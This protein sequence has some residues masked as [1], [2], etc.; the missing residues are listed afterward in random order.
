MFQSI[1]TPKAFRTVLTAA[2]V[3]LFATSCSKKDMQATETPAEVTTATSAQEIEELRQFVISTTGEDAVT[4]TAASKEFIIAGDAAMSLEDA[5]A[6]LKKFNET[7]LAGTAAGVQHRR[8]YYV[9]APAKA[10][11]VKIYADRTVPAV[12][13]TAL[14]KAIANWNAAGSKLKITRITTPTGAN[15]TVKGVN[16]GGNGVLAVANYPDY[17]SNA[18]KFVTINTY[19][20]SLSASKQIFA[21]THE[22]GHTYGFGHTNST[23]GT[24]VPGS[25]NVDPNS[26]MNAVCLNWSAFTAYD[27]QA[28]RTVYPK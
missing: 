25:P 6:Q 28:I 4:Y 14:D 13:I 24:L 1:A 21:I 7:E 19:Y 5:K 10:I 9:V 12:W 16:N 8:S 11:A 20:N 26:I 27:L 2:I 18:G 22:L 17:N 3:T 23:Y 15:T